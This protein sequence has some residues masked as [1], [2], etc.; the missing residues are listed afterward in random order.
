MDWKKVVWSDEATFETGKKR[1][2]L[3]DTPTG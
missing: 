3:R 2:G 1:E